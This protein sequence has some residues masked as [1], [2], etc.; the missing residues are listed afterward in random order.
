MLYHTGSIRFPRQPRFLIQNIEFFPTKMVEVDGVVAPDDRY[1]L[2]LSYNRLPTMKK[3]E[4]GVVVDTLP[5]ISEGGMNSD[6]FLFSFSFSKP[7][8]Y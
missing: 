7:S 4:M 3:Y 2:L 5:W 8:I 6:L 1:V